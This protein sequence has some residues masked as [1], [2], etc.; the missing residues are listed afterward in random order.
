MQTDYENR[1]MKLQNNNW[2]V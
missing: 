1:E 2:W